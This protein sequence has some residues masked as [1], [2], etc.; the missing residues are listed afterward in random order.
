MG[1]HEQFKGGARPP[2]R[3][4]DSSME[5]QVVTVAHVDGWRLPPFQRPLRV[6]DKVKAIA[7]EMKLSGSIPGILTMGRLVGDDAI[8]CV[9]GQHRAQAFKLTGL[10]MAQAN[11]RTV[12]FNSMSEMADEFVR[13]NSALVKMRPDD[14]LRG[15]E[16][17]SPLLQL[18]RRRCPFVGYD[19]IRR[20][21]NSPMVGMATT[22]RS[23]FA[24]R[25]EV[26]AT[27][28]AGS[29]QHMA[30]SLEASDVST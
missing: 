6:N 24:S 2:Q 11:V 26:P 27:A 7:E 28:V 25:P 23:W 4:G 3:A 18:I 14:V 17:T 12:M 8:Y 30:D 16:P 1:Q 15:R 13:L 29:A 9:D 5:K 21:E 10:P 22:L 19:M 20:G